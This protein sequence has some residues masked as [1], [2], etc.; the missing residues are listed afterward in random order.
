MDW[1]RYIDIYCERTAPG[2]WNEPLN[3]VSNGAFL[4][5]AFAAAVYISRAPARRDDRPVM[6]LIALVAVIGVGSFLFHTFAQYWAMLADVIPISVFI[7]AYLGF[8]LRRYFGLGWLVTL[9]TLTV[10]IAISFTVD[11]LVPADV[12]NGSVTYLPAVLALYAVSA[13]LRG[14]GHPA[15]GAM[16]VAAIVL[17]ASLAFRTIDLP[18]CAAWTSG[19]HYVW[20]SLNA[21]LLYWLMR[22]AVDHGARADRA[23]T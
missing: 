21:L 5:A 10:F 6:I 2:F 9:A 13:A 14:R 16:L 12:L 23:A 22:I 19:T 15:A 7:Y 18:L 1:F 8:A 3:A 4:I 17:T 11:A 20:H